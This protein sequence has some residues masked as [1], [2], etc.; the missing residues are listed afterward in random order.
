MRD[1][2]TDQMTDRELIEKYCQE[3]NITFSRNDT[4]RKIRDRIF[5]MYN[6]KMNTDKNFRKLAESTLIMYMKDPEYEGR[7]AKSSH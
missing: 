6:H 7:I 1:Q 3:V 4:H 5:Q 2:M